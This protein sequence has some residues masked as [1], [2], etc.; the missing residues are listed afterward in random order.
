MASLPNCQFFKIKADGKELKGYSKDDEYKNYIEGY[1]LGSVSSYKSAYGHGFDPVSARIL[2]KPGDIA[3]LYG[4]FL[5]KETHK[6]DVTIVHRTTN[7]NKPFEHKI[8]EYSG[9]TI[10]TLAIVAMEDGNTF[11][12]LT[13]TFGTVSVLMNAI[14]DDGKPVQIGPYVYNVVESKSE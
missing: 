11:Y 6:F 4:L 13:F 1:S 2:V 3:E 12:D 7:G 14:G 5:D 8:N 9:C 10:E